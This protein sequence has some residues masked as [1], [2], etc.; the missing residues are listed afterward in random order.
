MICMNQSALSISDF[1]HVIAL[2]SINTALQGLQEEGH[3]ISNPLCF[4][5]FFINAFYQSGK[6]QTSEYNCA[7]FFSEQDV[8][9]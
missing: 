3:S 2:S 7:I 8:A 6:L 4:V 5:V 1:T 9:F